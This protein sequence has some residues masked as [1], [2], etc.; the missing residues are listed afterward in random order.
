[1]SKAFYDVLNDWEDK[2]NIKNEYWANWCRVY[3]RGQIGSLEG[4]IFNNWAQIDNVPPEARLL[5]YGLDFG[6]TL[7]PTAVVALYQH[8]KDIYFDELIYER[9]LTNS[10]IA[11]RLKALGVGRDE[12]ICDSA[13][14]KSI[15][16][17]F[18]LGINAKP[19]VKG[20]D[21]IKA[22]IDILKRYKLNLIGTNLT[23]E[24]KSYKWK[25]DRKTNQPINEP[26]DFLNHLIDGIRY[27]ALNK[28]NNKKRG[29]YTIA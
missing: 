7:D 18:R 29:V 4:V 22:G 27:V 10:D 21:S 9:G 6:F 28:L 1:M 24:F 8:D 5:G 3:V 17:L 2:N 26:V 20:K 15:E 16:E 25:T 12:V 23:K 19:C 13:E 11:D 14:P